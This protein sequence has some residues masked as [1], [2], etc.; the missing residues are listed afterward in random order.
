MVTVVMA[1]TVMVLVL[2]VVMILQLGGME[3]FAG[4]F[5][6]GSAGQ[7]RTEDRSRPANYQVDAEFLAITSFTVLTIVIPPRESRPE[8]LPGSLM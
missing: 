4:D 3:Q 2:M 7:L 8:G 5:E 1:R 6:F